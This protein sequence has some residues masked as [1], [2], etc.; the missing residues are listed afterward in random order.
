MDDTTRLIDI[1]VTIP[2]LLERTDQLL[3]SINDESSKSS[4]LVNIATALESLHG[5]LNQWYA[6][7]DKPAHQILDVSDFTTF[8]RN[9]DDKTFPLA[10]QFPTFMI[11]YMHSLYWLYLRVV[12]KALMDILQAHPTSITMYTTDQL[13]NDVLQNILNLCQTIPYFCEHHASS[14]GRFAT[15]VPL[16][17]AMQYFEARQMRAQIGWCNKVCSTI[18]C[19]GISPPWIHGLQT[20]S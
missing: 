4:L 13:S 16:R 6:R 2:G 11:A 12:Q 3:Q 10:Y 9:C 18:Y 19:D 14:I 15:F 7:M 20:V 1:A 8:T 5:W 17:V